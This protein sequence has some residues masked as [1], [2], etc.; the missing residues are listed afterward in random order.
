MKRVA[1]VLGL[2]VIGVGCWA[3]ASSASHGPGSGPPADFVQGTGRNP[4]A[5]GPGGQVHSNARSGPDGEDPRGMLYARDRSEGLFTYTAEVEC[6]STLGNVAYIIARVTR[7]PGDF[8]IEGDPVAFRVEDNGEPGAG[9]DRFSQA[10]LAGRGPRS[11]RR[12]RADQ[13]TVPAKPLPG[14]NFEAFCNDPLLRVNMTLTAA[15]ISHG[16]FTVHD[17]QP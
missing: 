14:V 11:A 16:N 1:I 15:P 3:G 9:R 5:L 10:Q 12:R 6:L 4:G 2:A 8:L 13:Q 7:T 17:G